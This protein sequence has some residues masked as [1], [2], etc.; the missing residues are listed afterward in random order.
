[1]AAYAKVAATHGQVDPLDADAVEHFYVAVVPTLS[2]DSSRLL[3]MTSS[4]RQPALLAGSP[5]KRPCRIANHH[6]LSKEEG[7]RSDGLL[8]GMLS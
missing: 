6:C 2:P 3:L 7:F 5:T 4:W 1:M 8:W